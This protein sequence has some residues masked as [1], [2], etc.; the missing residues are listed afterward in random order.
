[1]SLPQSRKR[2]TSQTILFLIQPLCWQPTCKWSGGGGEI[3]KSFM[4][5]NG[6]FTLP[7]HTSAS[8]EQI[9]PENHCKHTE[10]FKHSKPLQACAVVTSMNYRNDLIVFSFGNT[11]GPPPCISVLTACG[12]QRGARLS[13]AYLWHVCWIQG[14]PSCQN[15]AR[16]EVWVKPVAIN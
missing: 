10:H 1:M 8:T 9:R 7:A 11:E 16:A 13:A 12:F 4:L 15:R 2:K 14:G 5:H 6:L 3:H